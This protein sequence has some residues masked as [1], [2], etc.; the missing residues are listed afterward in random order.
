[1]E[2]AEAMGI[3]DLDT[4]LAMQENTGEEDGYGSSNG[5]HSAARA[6]VNGTSG[7][8]GVELQ[9]GG[10]G[11]GKQQGGSSPAV[12]G[13]GDL[14]HQLDQRGQQA[15]QSGVAGV[16]LPVSR[17][18]AELP[19][20]PPPA[21]LTIRTSAPV[22]HGKLVR[23]C[24]ACCMEMH[25]CIVN[26]VAHH[27]ISDEALSKWVLSMHG[28]TPKLC[29]VEPLYSVFVRHCCC[30]GPACLRAQPCSRGLLACLHPHE[31]T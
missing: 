22:A 11:R 14:R 10:L 9:S 1:M 15:G 30:G 7:R 3:T 26:P 13:N 6:G 5:Q 28:S 18:A 29:Q 27:C 21:N 31:L 2:D 16:S 25:C 23:S 12:G 24:V 8:D 4:E 17:S 19:V 20:S